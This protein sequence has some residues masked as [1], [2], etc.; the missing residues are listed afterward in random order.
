MAKIT[1]FIILILIAFIV[2]AASC[3]KGREGC[4]DIAACNY[5]IDAAINDNSCW[6]PSTGCDCSDAKGSQVDCLGVCDNNMDNDPGDDNADGICNH[7][8]VGGCVDSLKCNFNPN[9]THNDG[10]CAPNLYVYGGTVDGY[11]CT[12][13]EDSSCGGNAVVDNCDLC[14]GGSTD[15]GQCW[16]MKV[17]A[18]AT[19]KLDNGLFLG[20]DT[21]SIIIG[22]SYNATDTLDSQVENID[23]NCK[24]NYSDAVSFTK[25]VWSSNKNNFI[26][27]YIPHDGE[28]GWS[29]SFG[30]TFNRDI[31]ANN[32]QSL[33]NEEQGLNWFSVIEPTMLDTLIKDESG[34]FITHQSILDTIKFEVSFLEGLKCTEMKIYFD[35][36]R[37]ESSGG[38]EFILENNKLDLKV[39]TDKSFSIIFNISNICIQEFEESCSDDYSNGQ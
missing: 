19:F 13:P 16:Q 20:K 24:E 30:D 9:A 29:S 39:E 33:L 3:D 5:D 10:S 15:Y 12:Y 7:D 4:T 38:E 2:S 36:I 22:A 31:R 35:R 8:V 18:I 37:G 34:T 23:Q 11:D 6:Y 28:T 25:T 26:N 27:F 32:F 21:S 14:V 17:Q 1:Q